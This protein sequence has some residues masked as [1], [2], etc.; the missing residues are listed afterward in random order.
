VAKAYNAIVEAQG[1]HYADAPSVVDDA[2]GNGVTDEFIIPS[3][4][5]GY[6][7]MR[8]GDGLLCFNFRADRVREILGAIV[9]PDFRRLPAQACDPLRRRCR[10]DA[11][12]YPSRPLPW[13]AV[14][15]ADHGP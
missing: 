11:V 1:P 13:H 3:C 14:P 5:N 4:V 8:D 10:D 2:Y 12:Q 15:A 9:D 6:R 7:G